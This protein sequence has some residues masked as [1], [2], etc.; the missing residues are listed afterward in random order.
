ML[1]MQGREKLR[2]ENYSEILDL[3]EEKVS[4]AAGKRIYDISGKTIC[5]R[6]VTKRE[7]FVEGLIDRIEIRV[8]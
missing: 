2:L 5:I 3:T 6:S 7:L 4:I 1:D 8:R